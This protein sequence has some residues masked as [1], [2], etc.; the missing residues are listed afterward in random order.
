M[1]F[2]SASPDHP[3]HR[4]GRSLTARDLRH[5]RRI[6]IRDTSR[7]RRREVEGVELRWTVSNKATSIRAIKMGLG[8]AWVPEDT[9]RGELADGSLKRL[10][11]RDGDERVA[12]LYIL[13]ADPESPG[14]D[15]ARLA[16]ILEAQAASC[17]GDSREAIK[18]RKG[19]SPLP[20]EGRA[21]ARR[22]AK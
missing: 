15:T 10:H 13:F 11:L 18:A 21:K 20:R 14:R 16:Q 1:L 4:L 22:R 8:F 7:Q 2:R 9:V 17:G 6:L 3:L 5:H 12:Q 19:R